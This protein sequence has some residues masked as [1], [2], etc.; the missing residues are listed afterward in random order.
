[1][2]LAVIHAF[3]HREQPRVLLNAARERV[4]VPGAGM[5]VERLPAGKSGAS[6]RHRGVHI[7]L[8]PLRDA[9]EDLAIGWIDDV[10]RLA[11]LGPLAIDEVAE[12]FFVFAEPMSG[13]LVRLGGGTVLHRSENVGVARHGMG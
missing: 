4:E 12:D 3:D 10:E 9:R 1:Y 2:R 7:G 8:G 13:G 5:S 6:R 11:R